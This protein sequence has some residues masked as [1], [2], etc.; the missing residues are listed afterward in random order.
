[1]DTFVLILI[2][3]LILGVAVPLIIIFVLLVIGS[4]L[5]HVPFVP[6]NK[7]VLEKLVGTLAL[8]PGA[9]FYDLGCGDGRVVTAVARAYPGASATGVELAPLPYLLARTSVWAS[10]LKN[11]RVV[12][13]DIS[14]AGLGH[15]THVFVYLL[16]KVLDTLL[17]K[18]SNELAPGTRLFSLDFP[19]KSLTP[20]DQYVVGTG[21]SRHTLYEYTF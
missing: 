13:S 12:R 3:L 1:M 4:W 19:I 15:A 16:P 8:N 17:F 21:S 2:A 11:A 18:L 14:T 7:A 10:G 6:V 9:Q 20:V 5:T